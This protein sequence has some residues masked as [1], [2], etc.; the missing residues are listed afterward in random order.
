MVGRDGATE[1]NP[2]NGVLYYQDFYGRFDS[3]QRKY[4]VPDPSL[5]VN[6]EVVHYIAHQQDI[7]QALNQWEEYALKGEHYIVETMMCVP[8]RLEQFNQPAKY[9]VSDSTGGVD[10]ALARCQSFLLQDPIDVVEDWTLFQA[11]VEDSVER[12]AIWNR[13]RK[14]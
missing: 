6:H 13:P 5:F 8:G 11:F 9:N 12:L 7:T 10:T 4:R 14:T 1:W 3:L 2:E